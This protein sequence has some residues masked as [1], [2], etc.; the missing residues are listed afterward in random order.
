MFYV[1]DFNMCEI[2]NNGHFVR[3]EELNK[4]IA[5]GAIVIN[6]EKLNKYKTNTR[7]RGIDNA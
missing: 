5:M 4:M 1:D 2:N 6:R 3:I 7:K